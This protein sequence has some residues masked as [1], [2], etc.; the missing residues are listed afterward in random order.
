MLTS[1][2]HTNER[3]YRGREQYNTAHSIGAMPQWSTHSSRSSLQWIASPIGESRTDFPL[4]HHSGPHP[5]LGPPAHA[6]PPRS[7]SRSQAQL[8]LSPL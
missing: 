4:P 7:N 6:H 5:M 8:P 1:T 2:T 3:L